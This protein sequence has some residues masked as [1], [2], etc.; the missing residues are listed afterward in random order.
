MG[1][2]AELFDD[3]AFG[4]AAM[5]G[6]RLPSLLVRLAAPGLAPGVY[7]CG[8][9]GRR[10]QGAAGALLCVSGQGPGPHHAAELCALDAA[11]A[12]LLEPA[13]LEA[14]CLSGGR[15]EGV[16]L[17]RPLYHGLA[18]CGAAALRAQVELD[19]LQARE[20]L[21]MPQ[22]A[23]AVAPAPAAPAAAVAADAAAAAVPRRSLPSHLLA[24]HVTP[25]LGLLE[26][27]A[28]ASASHLLLEAASAC[29][30]DAFAG[31]VCIVRREEPGKGQ[32]RA[33]QSCTCATSDVPMALRPRCAA[34]SV[35][36]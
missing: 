19:E 29:A 35:P 25:F 26:L 31:E 9:V 23:P 32:H 16:Q 3:E 6:A 11:A 28:W 17:L 12:G 36:Q 4:S 20:A 13:D 18:S 34:A 27:P 14:A 15:L 22:S 21:G 2:R 1:F 5:A 10:G 30:A 7:A 8:L 24:Y 33:A